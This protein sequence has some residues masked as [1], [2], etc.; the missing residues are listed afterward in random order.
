QKGFKNGFFL[1]EIGKDGV[2]DSIH[3]MR[4]IKEHLE[5]DIMPKE[6]PAEFFGIPPQG[7]DYERQLNVIRDHVFD[8]IKGLLSVPEEEY[9]FLSKAAADKGKA[10]I[11]KKEQYK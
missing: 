4:L 10:E 11:W 2:K 8:P 6:L 3:V 5:K 7:P 9:T 1:F